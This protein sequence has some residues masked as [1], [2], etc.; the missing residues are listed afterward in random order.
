MKIFIKNEVK[1]EVNV[2]RNQEIKNSLSATYILYQKEEHYPH[3]APA[4][5]IQDY[6]AAFIDKIKNGLYYF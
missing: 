5:K 3:Y 2:D 1:K 6:D 4:I